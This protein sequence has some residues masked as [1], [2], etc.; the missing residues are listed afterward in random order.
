MSPMRVFLLD[1]NVFIEA[2]KR[3]YAFGIAPGYWDALIKH[4]GAG[5]CKKYRQDKVRN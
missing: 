4:A 5:R 2:A 3:Y 1:A